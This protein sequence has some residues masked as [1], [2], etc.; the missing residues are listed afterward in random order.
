MSAPFRTIP[1]GYKTLMS[2]MQVNSIEHTEDGVIPC[3]ERE[4]EKDGVGYMDVYIAAK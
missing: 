4:Y 2:Y 1:N 3:F